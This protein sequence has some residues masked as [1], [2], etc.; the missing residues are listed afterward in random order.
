MEEIKSLERKYGSTSTL[1][2][3]LMPYKY[4]PGM[5]KEFS[6]D[7]QKIAEIIS[8]TKDTAML[9]LCYA[10]KSKLHARIKFLEDK[11]DAIPNKNYMIDSDEEWVD[12]NMPSGRLKPCGILKIEPLKL[13]FYLFFPLPVPNTLGLKWILV[14]PQ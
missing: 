9:K 10:M 1:T 3:Q 13:K 8:T 6:N 14:R 2:D 5:I 4:I 11:L 7:V 12:E